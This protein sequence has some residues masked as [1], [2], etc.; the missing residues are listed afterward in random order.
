MKVW[1]WADVTPDGPATTALELLTKAREL[2]DEVA[3][4]ALGPGAATSGE[5]LGG[6]RAQTGFAPDGEVS[7]TPLARR[8]V[9]APAGLVDEPRPDLI[10]S[11]AS[12]DARDVGGRL[13]ART[14]S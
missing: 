13:Q 1:V 10:L 9:H 12:Y 5:A 2:G 3:A 6:H 4:V 14:G 7:T 11:P 8:A